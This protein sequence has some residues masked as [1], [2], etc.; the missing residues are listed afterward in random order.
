MEELG[1]GL[2]ASRFQLLKQKKIR[3]K[4]EYCIWRWELSELCTN[5]Y[6]QQ[7]ECPPGRKV[8][9]ILVLILVSDLNLDVLI[10]KPNTH[11]FSVIKQTLL[12]CGCGKMRADRSSAAVS[13]RTC[14]AVDKQFWSGLSLLSVI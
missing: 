8:E 6:Y 13:E 14:A 11:F 10:H 1:I 2:V 4:T 3:W 9:A 5:N 7:A 12:S